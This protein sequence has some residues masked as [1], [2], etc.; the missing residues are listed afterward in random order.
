MNFYRKTI[1][2]IF[3]DTIS[4]NMY[5]ITINDVDEY[6]QFDNRIVPYSTDWRRKNAV[7]HVKNQGH[8]GSCWAFSTTG[9]VEGVVAIDTGVLHNISEQQLVDC[10]TDEGNHG[11]NG[12]VMDQGFKYI[13]DNGGI[14]S[15]EEYPYTGMDGI[16]VLLT[17]PESIAVRMDKY[18]SKSMSM[19]KKSHGPITIRQ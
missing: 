9:S 4:Q 1:K 2:T 19:N 3:V 7:T 11:C 8:C 18:R 13:I 15:E 6:Y 5:D 16:Q 12:G 10:S 17:F 14:C